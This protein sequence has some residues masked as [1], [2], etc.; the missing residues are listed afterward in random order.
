MELHRLSNKEVLRN[1]SSLKANALKLLENGKPYASLLRYILEQNFSTI[2]ILKIP[3]LKAISRESGI[4]YDK[5]R[6]Y[7]NEI[8]QDLLF[9]PDAYPVFNFSKIHYE[10]VI[11]G[12]TKDKS[13]TAL[14]DKLPVVPR[15][16]DNITLP[17]FT[18][19]LQSSF[20]HVEK[21]EHEFDEDEQVVVIYLKVGNYNQYWHFRKD[22]ALAEDEISAMEMNKLSDEELKMELRVGYI[23]KEI[24]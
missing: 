16:G 2:G 1:I 8:Y 4:Q 17:F 22:K 14:V 10:F 13:I 23:K 21:V 19:Y 12:W 7:L 20:F 11:E 18:A 24:L 15:V 5:V 3:T 6:K 9:D